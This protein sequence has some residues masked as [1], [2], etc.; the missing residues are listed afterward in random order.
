MTDTIQLRKDGIW[1]G[2][3]YPQFSGKWE[4]VGNELTIT[5]DDPTWPLWGIYTGAFETEDSVS[6]VMGRFD[7][8]NETIDT[9]TFE[10]T[11]ISK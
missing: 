8:N 7:R 4:T 3:T 6:G 11:R 5:W 10:A 2:V 9:G 1:V